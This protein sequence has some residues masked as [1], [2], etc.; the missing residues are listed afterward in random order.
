MNRLEELRAKNPEL[1]F[2]SVRDP[3][4]RR[5]GRVIDYPADKLIAA[6][7]SACAM[8]EAGSKYLPDV[9]E[10]EADGMLE[11]VAHILRGDG[12]TQIGCCW[13]HSN[14]MNCLEYHR[15]SEHN[16]AV[17]DMVLLLAAQQDMEGYDLPEGKVTAFYFPKGT[18]I[19]VYATTLHFCPCEVSEDGFRCI[20]VLPRGTNHP[21]KNGKPEIGDGR[22]LWAQDKWLICHPENEPVIA[23]GAYPG[24]HGENFTVKY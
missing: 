15:A 11:E 22:L 13:G 23:R 3:E 18:V 7:E 14:K 17:S 21:L 8:P 24:L 20:V 6:C 16:I 1:P 12:S 10:L 5:F 4:F 19:E 2:F 9:P